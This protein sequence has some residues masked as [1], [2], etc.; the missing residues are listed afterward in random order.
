MEKMRVTPMQ[1]VKKGQEGNV[2]RPTETVRTAAD[3]TA[4][5]GRMREASA[6]QGARWHTKARVAAPLGS[7]RRARGARPQAGSARGRQEQ[8]ERRPWRY[9]FMVQAAVCGIILL[10]VVG[11]RAVDTPVTN[12]I[13][14]GLSQVVTMEVDIGKD[15]GRLQFVRDIV[16]PS[17]LTFWEDTADGPV[18]FAEPFV[19]DIVI[20]YTEDTPGIVYSGDV[21]TVYAAADGTVDSVVQGEDG[22]F[23]LRIRH[24]GG[25]DTVYGLLQGVKV[26]PGDTVTVGQE[27]ALALPG[28]TGVHLYFQ[29]LRAGKAFDPAPMLGL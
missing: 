17:V 11:F 14:D 13:T 4:L 26:A 9:D 25:V 2:T 29:A 21:Q 7:A 12:Q 3:R 18:M 23:I 8:P 19:G 27:V 15:L 10:A 6:K 20:G 1:I 5:H 24:E 28:Q 22:D 16:P